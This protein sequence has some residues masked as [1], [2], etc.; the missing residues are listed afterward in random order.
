MHS[1]NKSVLAPML[2]EFP[3]DCDGTAGEFVGCSDDMAHKCA[4]NQNIITFTKGGLPKEYVTTLA[5]PAASVT[6]DVR[7]TLDKELET[8]SVDGKTL[9]VRSTLLYYVMHRT[10]RQVGRTWFSIDGALSK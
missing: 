9:K 8:R 2:F 10:C 1:T 6:S 3:L 7:F 5:V 4:D